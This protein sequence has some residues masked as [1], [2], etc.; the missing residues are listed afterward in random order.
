M[1]GWWGTP[2]T[3]LWMLFHLLVI[4]IQAF[5]FMMLSVVYLSMAHTTHDSHTH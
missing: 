1:L 4:T 5:V 2:L 3:L